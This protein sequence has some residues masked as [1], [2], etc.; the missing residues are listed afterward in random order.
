MA[1]TTSN[2][3]EQTRQIASRFAASLPQGSIVAVEGELGAGK[4]HFIQ[5]AARGLGFHGAVTSPTFTIV[6]EYPTGQGPVFHI[7][8]YRIASPRDTAALGLEEIFAAGRA[9]FIEW[10]ERLGAELPPTAFRVRIAIAPDPQRQIE[11]PDS[12]DPT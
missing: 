12:S 5:G 4:T 8:L 3:P 1:T 7:D 6:H 10:P 9:T 11:L 2:S